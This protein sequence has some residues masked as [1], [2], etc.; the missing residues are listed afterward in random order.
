[1]AAKQFRQ[2]AWN[3]QLEADTR[4]LLRLAA[5]EDLG[6]LGDLTTRA[7]LA[8]DAAAR[9]AV[10]ARSAG[11]VAGSPAAELALEFFDPRLEWIAQL[12][13]GQ[14][15]APGQVIARIE[16]PA[17]GLLTAERTML[18]L[19]GRL[20]G[21]ATLT[22]RYVEAVRGTKAEIYDTRKTTPGWRRLEK[23]AVR[24]GGGQ[25]HRSGL[26]DAILIKDNHLALAG[27][28]LLA[29]ILRPLPA[30]RTPVE[31]L[32]RARRFVEIHV[33]RPL[34]AGL[35][36]ELEVD[37][38]EQIESVLPERPDVVLLDNMTPEQLRRAVALRDATARDVLLEASGGVELSTVREIARSGV[39]RISVGALTH[40][41]PWLDLGLD[42]LP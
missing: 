12:E 42:M 20:S 18:N 26:Y 24:C 19:L 36:V 33:P 4:S 40:S 17:A 37:T 29:P 15:V 34:R 3:E 14:T 13:D 28:E 16:G 22:S 1:M 7:L 5:D 32:R 2:Y 10:V 6:G 8:E 35:G 21:V 41:A 27:E 9:A 38:I 30:A 23:Y 39:E 11:I 25:N 31:A